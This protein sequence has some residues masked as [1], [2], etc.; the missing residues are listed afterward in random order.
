MNSLTGDLR[1]PDAD[2]EV[3]QAK[4]QRRIKL[5]VEYDGTDFCGWQRQPNLRT[6]QEDLEVALSKV[7]QEPVTVIGAGRTDSGVHALAQVVHFDTG[8]PLACENLIKGANSL[9]GRD[10]MILDMEE[11]P[12]TFHARFSAVSRS[13]RYRLI[14][15]DRPLLRRYAWHPGYKWN[16][17]LVEQTVG[18]I[19]SEH[20][21][22]SFSHARPGET[23]YLCRVTE[24]RWEADSDGSTFHITAD[25]FMHKMVRGLVGALI[26]LG[27]GYYAM[28]G[29]RHLLEQ[30]EKVGAVRTAPARGLVLVSVAY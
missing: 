15:R 3:R 13:Y 5:T 19:V 29:F 2:E 30:P 7:L 14:R 6:V 25:R 21:F 27:R 8:N 23:E 4:C 22:M 17:E 26:D 16:D 12:P 11:A 24:A 20:S 10:V 1:E 18:L 28:D 9:L